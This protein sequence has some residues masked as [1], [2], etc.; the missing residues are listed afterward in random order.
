MDYSSGG[1]EHAPPGRVASEPP[2]GERTAD[3]I[4]SV[5]ANPSPR[6]DVDALLPPD[7]GKWPVSHPMAKWLASAIR[8]LGCRSVLEFGAGWSSLVI[9][10]ALA[11]EGGG[12]LTSFEHEPEHLARDIWSRVQQTPHVDAALVVTPLRR[13]LSSHGWLWSYH[14]VRKRLRQRIPFDLVFIDAPPQRYG[15]TSPLFDAYPLLRPGAVIIL[16]DAARPRERTAIARWLAT[17]PDLELVVLD[18][19]VER[20]IAV[21]VRHGGGRRRLALRAVLGTFREQLRDW[22]KSS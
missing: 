1:C 19:E 22:R 7:L 5:Y 16:D 20:G 9:A 18:T 15:R 10:E 8:G 14:G 3:R 6:V 12:R 11:A 13:T 21:L 2:N 17:F 4:R